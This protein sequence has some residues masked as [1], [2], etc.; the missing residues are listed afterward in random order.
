MIAKLTGVV[1]SVGTDWVVVDVNGVG[2]QV[3]CSNRTLS[4]MAVGERRALVVET[5]IRDDRITLYGFAD[6]G[7]RDWFRLL[8]TIQGVGS[9]LALSILGVLDPDQLTRAIAA[10]D[11]TAL[12]RADGVGPKVAA[13]IVN[14]LKDKVGNLTLGA[15][16]SAAPAAGGKAAPA[17]GGPDNMVMADAVS[18]LVNLGYGRSEA[19][20]AVVAA[21]R[22]LGDGAGVSELIRHGLK[23]LSQ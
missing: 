20:G 12:T 4:R 22:K 8:T 6:A 3:A 5:F 21:G 17:A 7:E 16:A 14:E 11:K 13:R 19:F 1:D 10:Q 18:A 2:Y 9:R 23:E 15:S